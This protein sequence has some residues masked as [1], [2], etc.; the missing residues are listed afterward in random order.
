MLVEPFTA[1]ENVVLG[2]EAGFRLAGGIAR[3]RAE[4]ER[5]GREY[6]LEV[7]ADARV[8]DLGVG[9]RQRLEILKALYRGADLLI[10]DEPTAVLTPGRRPITSSACCARSPT[11]ARAPSSSPTSCA[12]SWTPP[13]PSR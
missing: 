8:S 6:R 2:A 4:L 1:L 10:L 7:D 11:R 5:L 3:A 13:T 12:R 9:Q